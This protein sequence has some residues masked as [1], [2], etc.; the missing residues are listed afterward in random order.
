VLATPPIRAYLSVNPRFGANE[1]A[2]AHRSSPTRR[3]QSFD[4][5]LAQRLLEITH[6]QHPD[7][8]S[9]QREKAGIL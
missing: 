9:A 7:N 8:S 4:R 6:E 1:G 2:L 5:H 3:S